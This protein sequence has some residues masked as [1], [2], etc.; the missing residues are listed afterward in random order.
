VLRVND[1]DDQYVNTIYLFFL[2]QHL[3][4]LLI[5]ATRALKTKRIGLTS[6][7]I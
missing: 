1:N 3:S 2:K 7:H 4:L 5:R 6:D